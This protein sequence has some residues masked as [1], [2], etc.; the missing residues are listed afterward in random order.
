MFGYI[1]TAKDIAEG[2]KGLNQTFM[3]GLCI[4]TKKLFGNLPRMFVNN[5]INFFNVLLHSYMG[6]DVDILHRRCF[7]SPIKK[8]TIIATSDIT[9]KLSIANVILVYL[10]MYD[11]IVDGSA[12]AKKKVAISTYRRTYNRAV[13]LWPE[14]DSM[15]RDYYEQLR[16]LEGQSCAS[17]DM[18]CHPFA[19]LSRQMTELVLGDNVHNRLLDLTYNVGKWIYLI[20]ALDDMPKDNKKSQYNLFVSAYGSMDSALE[21]IS[22]IEFVLY[23]A[24]NSIA[25][26][27]NDLKLEQYKCILDSTIYGYIRTRTAEVLDRYNKEES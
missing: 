3:C 8:R 10:N 27:F 7:S 24:L 4:S 5:D 25:I 21:H 6:I 15:M 20:D 23:G 17:I 12:S 2:A 13:K 11:D 22:E 26:A 19:Q 1:D 9:D 18:V 14:C 16:T